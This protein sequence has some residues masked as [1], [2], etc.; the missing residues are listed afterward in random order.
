MQSNTVNV[1]TANVF[2]RFE[3]GECNRFTISRELNSLVPFCL[4]RWQNTRRRITSCQS[5]MNSVAG[6]Q[7]PKLSEIHCIRSK[8][9]RHLLLQYDRL[10]FNMGGSALPDFSGQ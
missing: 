1:E 2:S 7:K 4:S 9:I 8:P 10:I 3:I 5:F 6:N